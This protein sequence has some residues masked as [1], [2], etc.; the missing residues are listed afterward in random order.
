MM[1]SN[2]KAYFK[3]WY[4]KQTEAHRVYLRRRSTTGRLRTTPEWYEAKL[5]EQKGHCAL[6]PTTEGD[7]GSNLHIDHDHSCCPEPVTEK[8]TCGECN[9][10][11]LCGPC[12]R[13]LATV[14]A[15]LKEGTI[16]PNKGTWLERA[17]R[18]LDSYNS[19]T[20]EG[21]A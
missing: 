14:E 1:A 10:G 5:E 7:A 2:R 9:R 15:V 8:R 3:S 6:C 20:K 16:V 11:L 13:R 4:K 18:Y 17:M 12:N 19:F 21:S